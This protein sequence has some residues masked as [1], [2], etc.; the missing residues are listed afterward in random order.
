[1]DTPVRRTTLRRSASGSARRRMLRPGERPLFLADWT[2]VLFVHFAVDPAVLQ[3]HVPFDLDLFRGRA[4]VS[5]VA[6]TQRNLRP[7]VGG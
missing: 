5:L 7:R 3:P 4:Y 2:D 1:M 6:F